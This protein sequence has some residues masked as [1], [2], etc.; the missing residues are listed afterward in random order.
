[1]SREKNGAALFIQFEQHIF[2]EC[3]VYRIEPSE[4][5]V[6]DEKL[7]FMQQG[8][9]KLHLLLHSFGEFFGLFVDPCS[10]LHALAPL[11][12]AG[13]GVSRCESAQ[14]AEQHQLLTDLHPLV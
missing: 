4:G 8:G 3:G 12:S 11:L 2:E 7:R 6:H 13:S 9:D 5:F 10:D 1:M 14:L